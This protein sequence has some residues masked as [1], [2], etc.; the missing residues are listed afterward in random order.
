MGVV[1]HWP[2]SPRGC[3]IPGSVEVSLVGA[4]SD[5]LQGKVSLPMAG[6]WNEPVLKVPSNPSQ[7]VIL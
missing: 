5:L 1:T 6:A 4:L 3:P 2:R 7:S